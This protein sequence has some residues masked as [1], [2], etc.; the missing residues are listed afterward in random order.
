MPL[1]IR[2]VFTECSLGAR[3]WHDSRSGGEKQRFRLQW[4][5]EELKKCEYIITREDVTLPQDG[6]W[7]EKSPLCSAAVGCNPGQRSGKRAGSVLL[8]SLY[9]SRQVTSAPCFSY[10]SLR[11]SSVPAAGQDEAPV[12]TVYDPEIRLGRMQT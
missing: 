4:T 1:L 8:S 3:H 11:F 12:S 6:W 2:H 10:W 9:Q 7:M 5:S